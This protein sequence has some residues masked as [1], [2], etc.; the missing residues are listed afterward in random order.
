M[1]SRLKKYGFINAKLRTR[2]SKVLTPQ[3]LEQVVHSVS[4]TEGISLLRDTF[5]SSSA[6]I[7][8]ET[9][10]LK[11]VEFELYTNEIRLYQEIEK[12]IEKELL[13]YVMALTVHYEIDVLKNLLRLWFDKNFKHRPINGKLKYIYRE[14]ILHDLNHDGIV[15]AESLEDIA[16][17][18]IDTP[19]SGIILSNGERVKNKSS[20][21]P[22]EIA[23]DKYFYGQ[24]LSNMEFLEE[25]DRKIA[26][27]LVGIEID[28]QNINWIIRLR[29]TYDFS[30]QET[31]SYLIAPH[32]HTVNLES[33]G[34]LE[35]DSGFKDLLSLLEKKNNISLEAF[36]STQKR[37]D[38]TRLSLLERILE[39]IMERQVQKMLAG[40]PFT[41]GIILAYFFLKRNEIRKIMTVLNAK[42]YQLP[43]ER[44]KELI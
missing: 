39:Q 4:L 37:P 24:L 17:L 3:Y 21:F 40:Y 5:Y 25:G 19:Y 1:G 14:K 2:L 23:L 22:I 6:I 27:D 32:R 13:R 44:I 38:V 31:M 33:L 8:E 15:N 11:M 12:Y 20:L 41:I 42:Y 34:N 29:K 7:Y 16:K 18:L 43:V 10:D 35:N 36:L 9:H 26:R 28:I 30:I